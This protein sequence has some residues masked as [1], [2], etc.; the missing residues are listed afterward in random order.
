MAHTGVVGAKSLLVVLWGAATGVA[1]LVAWQ[2]LGLVSSSTEVDLLE[3]QP[4]ASVDSS[5]R[6]PSSSSPSAAPGRPDEDEAAPPS[7][8]PSPTTS[9]SISATTVA[10]TTT[11]GSS[12]SATERT[13]TVEGGAVAVR[14]TPEQISVLWATPDPGY[15]VDWEPEHGGLKIEFE[16]DRHTTELE[17]WWDGGARH[18]ISEEGDS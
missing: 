8:S 3:S 7:V 5:A 1:A 6:T 9:A 18:Q 2:A 13:F 15:R 14:F 11:T 17:V 12:S 16:S 10:S 4:V